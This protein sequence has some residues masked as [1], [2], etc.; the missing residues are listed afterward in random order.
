MIAEAHPPSRNSRPL[1]APDTLFYVVRDHLQAH[2]RTPLTPAV[3][4]FGVIAIAVTVYLGIEG[5]RSA[6]SS[7]QSVP[8]DL[9][10]LWLFVSGVMLVTIMIFLGVRS[11]TRLR[12][13]TPSHVPANPALAWSDV[14]PVRS[15]AVA[16][17]VPLT[18][19]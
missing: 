16:G 1:D 18:Q 14:T 10:I 9:P 5:F 19:S 6:H 12:K 7:Q 8:S 17:H 15:Q 13:R 4:I 11:Q 2:Q 3:L